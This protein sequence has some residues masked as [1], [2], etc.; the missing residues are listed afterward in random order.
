MKR[1]WFSALYSCSSYNHNK[2]YVTMSIDRETNMFKNKGVKGQLKTWD[3][4][5][6]ESNE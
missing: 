3:V 1:A 6:K 2:G 4:L 5:N